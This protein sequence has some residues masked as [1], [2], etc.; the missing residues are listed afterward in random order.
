MARNWSEWRL[1]PDPRQHGI[2]EAP[3][4]P[5]CYELRIGTQKLLYGEGN[6]VAARMS[7]LLPAGLGSGNRKNKAK[8]NDVFSNLGKV[9]YRTL[10]CDTKKEAKAEEMKLRAS[11]HDYVHPD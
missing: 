2:L 7:S 5:G 3:I 6:N 10:A 4:G 8:Q 1:F 11:K 9:E